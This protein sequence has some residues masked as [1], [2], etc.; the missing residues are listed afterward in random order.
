MESDAGQCSVG[1]SRIYDLVAGFAKNS[2]AKERGR[3]EL[4]ELVDASF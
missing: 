2:V 4:C 3:S 1:C